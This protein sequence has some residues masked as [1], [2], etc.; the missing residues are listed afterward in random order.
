M[1][2][3]Q[4]NYLSANESQAVSLFLFFFSIPFILFLINVVTG[5][6]WNSADKR[7]QTAQVG[8]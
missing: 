6:E 8:K 3:G 2:T 1:F 4:S 7:L 5:S